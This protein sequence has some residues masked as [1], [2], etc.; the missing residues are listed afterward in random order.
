[1]HAV[2]IDMTQCAKIRRAEGLQP[3]SGG[4][5]DIAG[6]VD[7]VIEHDEHTFAARLRRA[8]HAEGIDE[9]HTSVGA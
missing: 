8:G 2:A 1:M 9:V 5:Y 6:G 4:L 3:V 7:L